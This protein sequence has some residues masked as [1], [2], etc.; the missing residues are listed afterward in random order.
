MSGRLDKGGV[1]RIGHRVIEYFEIVHPH[2]GAAHA[3]RSAVDENEIIS[4]E[5]AAETQGGDRPHA[6]TGL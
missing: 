6:C 1:F 3:E 2:L 5:E 4:A